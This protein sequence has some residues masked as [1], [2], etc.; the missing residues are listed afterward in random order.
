MWMGFVVVYNIVEIA[1]I[2]DH[3]SILAYFFSMELDMLSDPGALLFPRYL[4]H[5]SYVIL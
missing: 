5:K 2:I 4:R 1:G 3:E